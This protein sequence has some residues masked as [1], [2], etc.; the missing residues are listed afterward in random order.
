MYAFDKSGLFV[1]IST[2]HSKSGLNMNRTAFDVLVQDVLPDEAFVTE[3]IVGS[4]NLFRCMSRFPMM[5]SFIE[6]C[7]SQGGY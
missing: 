4:F 7:C 2:E 1:S 5:V 6:N 3:S